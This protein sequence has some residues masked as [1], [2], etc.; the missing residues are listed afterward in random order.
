MPGYIKK[1]LHKLQY[2]K[3]ATPEHNPHLY[4]PPAYGK[5]T[6]Y[7]EPPDTSTPLSRQ[8]KRRILQIV[9]SLLYYA[10]AVDNTILMAVN[11]LAAQQANATITKEAHTHKLLNYLA[12]HPDA[13]VTFK[14]SNM[15]LQ[16]HSDASYLSV[17]NSSSHSEGYFSWVKLITTQ[18]P[19]LSSMHLSM[20]NAK[21]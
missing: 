10:R 1:L 3:P 12:I 14:P 4:K 6:Q 7:V 15:V 17:P 2:T 13:S 19:I 9:G 21:S 20:L 18:M 16:V 11:D 5:Q 8:R